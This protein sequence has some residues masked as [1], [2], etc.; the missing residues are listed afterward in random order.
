MTEAVSRDNLRGGAWLIADMSLNIW[1]LSIVKWLG[2]GYPSTQIVFIRALVGLVLIAPLIW[3]GRASFRALPDRG[4]HLL[5]VVLSVITLSASFFAIPRVPFAVFTAVGFTRPLV[6]MV[7]AALL[8]RETIGARRWLAAGVAFAGVLVAVNPGAV[9]WSW[10]LAAL[11]IV[12]VSGSGAVIATRRLREAPP[13]VMMTF[14][15]AGL[16]LFSAPM[17]LSAWEPVARG[18]I[19]PLLLV[20][21]FAQSAQLCFLRAH[22]HGAAGFLSVLGYLSLVLSVGVGYFA[23]GE[24]P[25]PS[26][27]LGALLVVSSA[28]WATVDLRTIRIRS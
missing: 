16:T 7:M 11:A 23:F 25:A 8:L 20:G 22:Y 15:T 4:F 13:I 27:A 28:L 17:A 3:R 1:A 2:A 26:F 10:G 18:H 12:V 14:Y 9:E 24:E 5:R 21:C 19:L 6:T